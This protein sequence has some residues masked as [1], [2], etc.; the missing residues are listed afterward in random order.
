M[1]IYKKAKKLTWTLQC[2]IARY[3]DVW[4]RQR[5]SEIHDIHEIGSGTKLLFIFLSL[6]VFRHEESE[7]HNLLCWLLLHRQFS[8]QPTREARCAQSRLASPSSESQLPRS[9]AGT[10]LSAFSQIPKSSAH[11]SGAWRHLHPL[12]TT[13][14]WNFYFD[15][16]ERHILSARALTPALMLHL[17]NRKLSERFSS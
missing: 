11:T 9:V 12:V 17:T 8:T 3:T 1:L 14:I 10:Q 13:P 5:E 2:Y 6:K 15:I 4:N 16:S 7:R